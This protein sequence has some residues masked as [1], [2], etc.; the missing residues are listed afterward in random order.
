MDCGV[1]KTVGTPS[2]DGLWGL[3]G[4]GNSKSGWTAGFR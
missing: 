3:E 4:I 2:L 1:W